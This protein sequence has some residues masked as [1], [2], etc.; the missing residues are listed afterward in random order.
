VWK[1][2]TYLKFA[3][4]KLVNMYPT[5]PFFYVNNDVISMRLLDW[6]TDDLLLVC[7]LVVWF[8]KFHTSDTAD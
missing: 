1:F 6:S 2:H 8:A 7:P 5:Q 3:D 4:E